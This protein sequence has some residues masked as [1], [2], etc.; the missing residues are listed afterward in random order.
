MTPAPHIIPTVKALMAGYPEAHINRVVEAIR[1]GPR[2]STHDLAKLH[3]VHRVTVWRWVREGR[4]PQPRKDR[5]QL[6]TWD[7]DEVKEIKKA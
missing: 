3:H 4:I 6:R 7:Y 5:K 1:K 2:I